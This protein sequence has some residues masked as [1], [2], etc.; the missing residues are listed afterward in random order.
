MVLVRD[1]VT[2]ESGPIKDP[3]PHARLRRVGVHI[4]QLDMATPT[5]ARGGEPAEAVELVAQLVRERGPARPQRDGPDPLTLRGDQRNRAHR[6]AVEPQHLLL[7][8]GPGRKEVERGADIESLE[9]APGG[10]V[11]VALAARA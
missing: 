1:L 6:K 9:I 10:K 11:A 8:V 3:W 4:W 7:H 2:I 5:R